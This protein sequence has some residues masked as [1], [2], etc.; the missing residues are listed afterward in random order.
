MV[1]GNSRTLAKIHVVTAILVMFVLKMLSLTSHRTSMREDSLAHKDFTVRQE[2]SPR[3]HV[4]LELRELRKLLV[5]LMN[6]NP[7]SQESMGT[8]LEQLHVKNA[9]QEPFLI[10]VHLLA[11]VQV[12]TESSYQRLEAV[13]A[14]QDSNLLILIMMIHSQIVRRKFTMTVTVKLRKETQLV[15]AETKITVLLHAMEV[16][17][18]SNSMVSANAKTS[19]PLKKYA[20]SSVCKIS[21]RFISPLMEPSKSNQINQSRQ[22]SSSKKIFLELPIVRKKI[23]LNVN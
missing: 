3:S 23:R 20:Q 21:Q 10:W 8:R 14:K 2:L 16:K 13:Y 15:H 18:Q 22:T 6:V 19:R 7:V 4:L 5:S 1:E 9:H 17:A 11:V 12:S